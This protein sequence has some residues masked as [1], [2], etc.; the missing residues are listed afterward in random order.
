MESTAFLKDSDFFGFI[1]SLAVIGV[2]FLVTYLI[3]KKK[4]SAAPQ[5]EKI[6]K[7]K[8]SNLA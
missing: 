3:I 4:K 8:A 2:A 1:I 5:E 6:R 7:Y